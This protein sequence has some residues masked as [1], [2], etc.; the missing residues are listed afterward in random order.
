MAWPLI[1]TCIFEDAT[2]VREE[3]LSD[4]LTTADGPSLLNLSH[5]LVL[6]VC[7]AVLFHFVPR[8]ILDRMT[9]A[10]VLTV[11][12]NV[13]CLAAF[14][15]CLVWLTRLVDDTLVLVH[16]LVHHVRISAGA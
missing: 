10:I 12:A 5:H 2:L 16:P 13:F 14:R 9:F 11:S 8:R 4:S 15:L 1:A 6:S 7:E 3:C